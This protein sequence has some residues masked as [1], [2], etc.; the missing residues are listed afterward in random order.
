M[1][2]AVLGWGSLVWDPRALRLSDHFKPNGPCLPLEFCRVSG[3]GRLTLVIDETVGSPCDTYA[4]TTSFNVLDDAIDDLREREKIPRPRNVGTYPTGV[5]YIDLTN[6]QTS[7][8]AMQRHPGAV[9]AI[10]SW[11]NA[12]GYDATIWTALASNLP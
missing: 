6:G 1:R 8:S 7:A 10:Q 3:D 9:G 12:N 11:T 2:I 4:A 5:G